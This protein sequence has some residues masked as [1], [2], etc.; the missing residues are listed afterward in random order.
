MS[1]E[2]C[3]TPEALVEERIDRVLTQYRE[4]PKLLFMM[5]TYLSKI[6]STA[7]QICD[8][9][10]RFNLETATGDQ[11]T[12]IGKRMGWPRCHCI[13]D[14]QPV[15]G[16]DCPDEV[17]LRPVAGFGVKL[18]AANFG[19]CDD[20]VGFGQPYITNWA[21]CPDDSRL[22]QVDCVEDS[23]WEICSR[24]V[25]EVCITD[26]EVYRTFLKVRAYQIAGRFDRASLE[27]SIQ[28]FFGAQA[29]ILYEGQRRVVFAP[30]RELSN[31]EITLLQL[32]ARV[33]PLA[34]G[35]ESRF[36]FGEQK[37]FGF[38]EGWGGFCDVEFTN[39]NGTGKIFSFCDD[40]ETAGGF[41]EV[42]DNPFTDLVTEDDDNLAT[43]NGDEIVIDRNADSA[44][45]LCQ[46]GSPWMCEVDVQPYSC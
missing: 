28:L 40:S 9:P 34:L 42:L 32:Y 7:L 44:T 6:A 38:G 46:Q 14:V 43:V 13:C 37:V 5:Q 30:G 4:S 20:A 22:E 26:D 35:I 39:D 41:C 16:F 19:F 10:E 45:W 25:A 1:N 8:L 36:Y 18:D 33:L 15:F 23:T 21:V 29:K 11:L 27:A 2:V 24:G 31:T 17:E 3:P 12:L